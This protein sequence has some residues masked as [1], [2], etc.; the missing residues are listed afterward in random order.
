MK[1]SKITKLL[2]AMILIMAILNMAG[3]GAK[4]TEKST[5]STGSQSGSLVIRLEGG[6]WGLPSP[7]AHYS[8]GPGASKMRLIYDSLLEKGEDGLIPWLAK[9][10]T[11][12]SDGREYTFLLN[13]KVKW[14]DGKMLTAQDVKFSFEYFAKHP[15]V[16]NSLLI[17]GKPFIEKIEVIDEDRVKIVVKEPNATVLDRVGIV[18]IIPEHIWK[19]IDDP[20]KIMDLDKLV[21]CGPYILTDYSQEQGK[22]RFQA[23]KDY[24]GRKPGVD[25]IEFIP[26]SDPVLAFENG[27]IDVLDVPPDLID[28]Y[29][30]NKEFKIL[31]SPAFWGYKL[32]FNMEKKPELADINVRKAIAHAVNVDELIEKVARGA[33]VPASPGYLPID[34]IWYNPDVTRYDFDIEKAKELLNNKSLNLALLISDSQQEARIAEL[35]KI[36]FAKAGIN[37]DVRS[38]DM[39]TRDSCV[40]NCDYELAIIGHGGWGADADCLREVYAATAACDAAPTSNVICGYSNPGINRLC[41]EQLAELDEQKRKSMIMELQKLISDEIPILPIYNTI[42]YTVFK[43]EK[44]DGWVHVFDHHAVTHNKLS[45]LEQDK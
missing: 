33:A 35:L 42:D 36:N 3:C 14:H 43:P 10:W 24:W 21:G 6:D 41:K 44:Y 11:I 17:D 23:F 8:R 30:N 9:E 40:K 18:R 2:A 28:R 5:G 29:R 31:K 38:V 22:Y 7:F 27:E 19:D 25:V 34:H 26:V 13:S 45:Y 37:I 39:K 4:T 32:L 20:K 12:S 15:P 1:K 16:S